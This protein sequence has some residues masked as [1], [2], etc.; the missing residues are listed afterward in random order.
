MSTPSE[1][2]LQAQLDQG[3]LLLIARSL[4]DEAEAAGLREALRGLDAPFLYGAQWFFLTCRVGAATGHRS[5]AAPTAPTSIF[6]A[7]AAP[8]R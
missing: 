6:R 2:D 4:G 5:A 7:A 1:Q 8:G 3:Y